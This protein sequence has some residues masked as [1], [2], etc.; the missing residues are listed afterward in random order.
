MQIKSC[1]GTIRPVILFCQPLDIRC[2]DTTYYIHTS[3]SPQLC[4]SAGPPISQN[5]FTER[6]WPTESL[7]G[8]PRVLPAKGCNLSPECPWG[9]GSHYW[10][11]RRRCRQSVSACRQCCSLAQIHLGSLT[12]IS[13]CL[14]VC[15]SD[16][17]TDSVCLESRETYNH[18][19]PHIQSMSEH[20]QL[21]WTVF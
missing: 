20:E 21:S 1:S 10:L 14:F 16:S 5:P 19:K 2:W 15:L 17:E 8:S 7:T 11:G 3:N 6:M 9:Q 13:D 18:S 12:L 4:N